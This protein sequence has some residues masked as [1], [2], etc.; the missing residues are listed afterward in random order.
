M[1]IS[2][3]DAMGTDGIYTRTTGSVIAM[4]T[5]VYIYIYIYIY[6]DCSSFMCSRIVLTVS[7]AHCI[8]A[9]DKYV[10][11]LSTVAE[12]P[13]PQKEIEPALKLLGHWSHI[14]QVRDCI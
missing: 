8:A 5:N 3:T 2:D 13:N 14:A 6:Y 7:F 10:A 12:T 11:I 4:V 9:K 1:D